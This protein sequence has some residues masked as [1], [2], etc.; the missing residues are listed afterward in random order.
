MEQLREIRR[1]IRAVREIQ[2]ITRAM[3]LV[4]AAKL[5]KAQ[6]EAEAA[7]PFA[8]KISEVLLDIAQ[9]TQEPLHPLM[10]ARPANKI[11]F[12]VMTSDR[13]LCGRFNHDIFDT[14][15]A[16]VEALGGKGKA[17]MIV[18]GRKGLEFFTRNGFNIAASYIRLSQRPTFGW[19]REIASKVL[20][21]YEAR[22]VDHVY[23]I[24]SRFYSTMTHRPKVFRLIPVVPVV[25]DGTR[26]PRPHPDVFIFNPSPGIVL[27]HLV[28][29]YIEVEI[30]RA[31]QETEASKRGARM[32]A[33]SA[34]T[35]NAAE[36]IERL[37]ARYNRSRQATITREIADI[38]GGAEVVANGGTN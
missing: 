7:R 6:D 30:F 33:M 15:L 35:D 16:Q 38:I 20:E 22:T 19:A 21:L 28:S 34:A 31:L 37:V 5:K 36:M 14:T 12:I 13:G 17:V 11:G 29:R 26:A 9:W 25:E 24:Y 2:H 32:T 3:K 23:I 4:A 18:V 10:A 1:H 8:R 27:E